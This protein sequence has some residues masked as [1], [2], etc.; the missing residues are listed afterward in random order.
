MIS[1]TVKKDL[2]EKWRTKTKENKDTLND[3]FTSCKKIA[4]QILNNLVQNEPE[5]WKEIKE[6]LLKYFGKSSLS[7]EEKKSFGINCVEPLKFFTRIFSII[8]VKLTN[9]CSKDLQNS[10]KENT[11][12]RFSFIS[13][14]K[15]KKRFY[16]CFYFIYLKS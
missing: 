10:L 12:H 2:N 14:K 7:E 16:F 5:Y 8:G 15:K 4:V 11:Y 1:R 3:N 6:Q 13:K 9:N